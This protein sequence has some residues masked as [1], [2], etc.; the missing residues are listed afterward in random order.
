MAQFGFL[1][2]RPTKDQNQVTERPSFHKRNH[3]FGGEW[4]LTFGNGF[5]NT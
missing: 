3:Q 5:F 1:V 4:T 2:I